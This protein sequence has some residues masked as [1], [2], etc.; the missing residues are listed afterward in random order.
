[1]HLNHRIA[2]MTALAC[3][4]VGTLPGIREAKA[5]DKPEAPAKPV[6][7]G[8]GLL[9]V[10]SGNFLDKPSDT[11]LTLPNGAKAST[12]TYPGFGGVG[13]GAGLMLDV[14][15]RDIV[16]LEIDVLRTKD[17]GHGTLTLNGR[18][19]E[20]DIGQSAWHVP[21]YA[22][23]VAPMPTVRPMVFAGVDLVFPSSASATVTNDDLLVTDVGAYNDS[24]TMLGGGIGVEIC[25][26]VEGID[27]RIP[28]TLRGALNTGVTD[29]LDDRVKTNVEQVGNGYALR[30]IDYDSSWKYEAQATLGVSAH[31]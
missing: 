30:R 21:I 16:G 7:F 12:E 8:V 17:R 24:Y 3:C 11:H 4:V 31:F 25:L 2:V 14:R 19:F 13:G 26:P 28:V 23:L 1:M 6:T 18:D 15:Y 10:M 29:Q 22:K 5:Q 9:G 20:I 27:L